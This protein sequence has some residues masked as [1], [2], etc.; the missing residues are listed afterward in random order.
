LEVVAAEALMKRA[1]QGDP[2]AD[3]RERQWVE[4]P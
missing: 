1:L 3:M 4:V 2:S